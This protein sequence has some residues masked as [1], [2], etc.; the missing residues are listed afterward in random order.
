MVSWIG[1]GLGVGL[2]LF[3]NNLTLQSVPNLLGE[4]M[5]K[6]IIDP[7]RYLINSPDVVKKI[8]TVFF[9]Q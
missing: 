2:V 9:P 3:Y 7:R 5:H 6:I 4:I 1:S 8:G